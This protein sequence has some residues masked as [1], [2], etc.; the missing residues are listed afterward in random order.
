MDF[1]QSGLNVE[2]QKHALKEDTD[3]VEKDSPKSL[4]SGRREG[5]RRQNWK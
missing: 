4:V 1:V 3:A 5:L 2:K